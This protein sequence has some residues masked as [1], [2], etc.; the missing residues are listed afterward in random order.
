MS[1]TTPVL[2]RLIVSV[3]ALAPLIRAG[4]VLRVGPTR[5]FAT[6]DAAIAAAADGD[7]ILVDP[8]SYPPFTL[9]GRSLA[10][11]A[12]AGPFT[13]VPGAQAQV[14]VRNVPAGGTVTV[15]GILAAIP[16][17]NA[18]AIEIQSCPGTVRIGEAVIDPSADLPAVPLRAAVEITDCASVWLSELQ[19]TSLT[20][21]RGSTINY[22]PAPVGPNTGI[23]AV[24]AERS[25]VLLKNV[26]LRGYDDAGY[27]GDGLRLLGPSAAIL[28]A[29]GGNVIT[30]GNGVLF[31]GNAIHCLNLGALLPDVTLC[32]HTTLVPGPGA[33][34]GGYFARDHDRGLIQS[35]PIQIERFVPACVDAAASSASTARVWSLGTV[36]T[37][38][39][40]ALLG[41]RAFVLFL[42]PTRVRPFR[43]PG[44]GNEALL[45]YL[46][47]RAIAIAAGVLP[48]N[49]IPF[50]VP[51]AQELI[52]LQLA[53][54]AALGA[55]A[56]MTTPVVTFTLGEWLVVQ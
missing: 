28:H 56:G 11:I 13:V 26:Q 12:A 30:G 51:N 53:V 24:L 55:P 4:Q 10:V 42:G 2:S 22:I 41:P 50:A 7:L 14:R 27:G 16:T 52:G 3:L 37:I 15:S 48:T 49:P 19:V 9:D 8:G 54:Q 31:G 23:S 18:P 17:G 40:G 43:V 33:Y 20:R 47:P 34:R 29:T 36:P 32:G 44:V 38:G 35:G 39:V 6:I 5:P 1:M 25:T 46:T 45:D 21:R